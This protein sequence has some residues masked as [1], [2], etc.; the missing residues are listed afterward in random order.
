M[1]RVRREYEHYYCTT[2]ITDTSTAASHMDQASISPLLNCASTD[3]QDAFR[4]LLSR[5][6]EGGPSRSKAVLGKAPPK[7]GWDIKSKPG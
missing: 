5:P 4:S 2:T 7:R 6:R 1:R 3:H